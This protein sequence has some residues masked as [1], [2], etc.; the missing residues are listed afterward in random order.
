MRA[1]WPSTARHEAPGPSFPKHLQDARQSTRSAS[2]Q[3]KH[4]AHG[5]KSRNSFSSERGN[6]SHKSRESNKSLLLG[7]FFAAF[8]LFKQ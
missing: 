3:A 5:K 6:K 2:T 8:R 7:F 1:Q 4:K